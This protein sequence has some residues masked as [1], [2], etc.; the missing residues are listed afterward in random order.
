M[1]LKA[2]GGGAGVQDAI[3]AAWID[4]VQLDVAGART[5]GHILVVSTPP[6]PNAGSSVPSALNQAR[7]NT[8]VLL[9]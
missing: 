6:V 8:D 2:G 7:P 3:P 5:N 4:P 9:N 1:A